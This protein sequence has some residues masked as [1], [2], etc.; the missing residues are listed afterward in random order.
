MPT[1]PA[2]ILLA[3][4][5]SE[6]LE[7]GE[8]SR[9][10]QIGDL[11]RNYLL[12]V[13]PAYDRAKPTPVLLVFHGGGSNAQVMVDFC[14]LN[15]KADEANFLGVYPNGTGRLA[16]VL[17]FNGGNCCG[18]AKNRNIDDVEFTRQILDD[19]GRMV[20]VD[21][22]RVFATGMSN[23]AL[24]SYRLANELS[25]R[26]AAIAPVGGPMGTKSCAPQHP[27]SVIHFHGTE[28]EYAPYKGGRGNGISATDFYSAE[29]SVQ[30][31]A[32][33]NECDAEPTVTHFQD[34]A[35]DGTTVTRTLYGAGKEGAEVVLYT[36]AGAGHT[37][38]GQDSRFRI[39]GK[40]TKNISANDL[41]WEFFLKHPKP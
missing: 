28:D 27:V 11:Q 18:Y 15:R 39:L 6:L 23:G 34:E 22:K 5:S 38:P 25:D 2:R 41:L 40:S 10:L 16:T 37:W 8:Y 7:P 26:I 21:P 33:A 20:N 35:H 13:P 1:V 17:T 9:T 29:H 31:W 14:G 24:M 19:L 12:H 36:I 4:I 30:A 3:G 32:G